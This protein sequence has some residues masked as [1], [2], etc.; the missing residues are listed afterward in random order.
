M[1]IFLSFTWDVVIK[2]LNILEEA[3]EKNL[4]PPAQARF[5]MLNTGGIDTVRI[6]SSFI[7]VATTLTMVT[8]LFGKPL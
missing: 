6:I 5:W 7:F 4:A 2:L 3:L 1:L 8:V